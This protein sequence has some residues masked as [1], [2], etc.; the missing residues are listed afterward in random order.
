MGR[1][2]LSIRAF[3]SQRLDATGIT[4]VTVVSLAPFSRVRGR[5]PVVT[6]SQQALGYD[7]VHDNC[8]AAGT[9]SA[10][11]EGCLP[12]GA[13]RRTRYGHEPDDHVRPRTGSPVR[14]DF[15]KRSGVRVSNQRCSRHPMRGVD[16]HHEEDCQGRRARALDR[17]EL[18]LEALTSGRFRTSPLVIAQVLASA[19]DPDPADVCPSG[20]GGE[21]R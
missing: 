7:Q 9:G 19:A 11:E 16:R 6:L 15:S 8:T 3:R 1:T 12:P 4:S 20:R 18:G 2:H 14:G 13:P 10:A 21:R 17:A 5:S